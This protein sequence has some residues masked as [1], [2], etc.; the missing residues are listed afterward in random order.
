MPFSYCLKNQ[1]KIRF[2][3]DTP[4]RYNRYKFYHHNQPEVDEFDLIVIALML[5][6]QDIEYVK[7]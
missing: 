6:S 1:T 5:D 3:H 2:F 4:V 7:R